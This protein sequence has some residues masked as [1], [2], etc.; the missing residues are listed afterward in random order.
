MSVS[1]GFDHFQLGGFSVPINLLRRGIEWKNEEKRKGKTRLRT[2][3]NAEKMRKRGGNRI[4]G[5][6]D[7]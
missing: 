4:V 3:Y 7:G 6:R 1:P 5:Q 2:G